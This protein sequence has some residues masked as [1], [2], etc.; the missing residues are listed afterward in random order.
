MVIMLQKAD[1][2][3][4]MDND[5]DAQLEHKRSREGTSKET[6]LLVTGIPY[7]PL[8]EDSSG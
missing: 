8:P 4:D 5:A 3:A 2:T 7:T 6:P 1:G